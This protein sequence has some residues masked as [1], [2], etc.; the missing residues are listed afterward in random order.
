V[1]RSVSIEEAKALVHDGGEIAFLDLREAGEFGEGHPLFA[2]P[3]PYS[4]LEAQVTALVPLRG[5]RVLLIDGGDG[6][7]GRAAAALEATGYG[8]VM[9]VAGGTPAWAAA[10]HTLFQGVNVPSKTLGELAEHAWHPQTIDAPTLKRWQDEGRDF[11]FFDA[12]PPAE[13][14]KMRVP[15]A[16]CLP[17][18]ELAHR[19]AA[20]I[21]DPAAP[22]VVTCAGRTRGI[23]GVLGLR[24]A[25][26]DRPVYALEN[27]TQ[28]WQLAGFPLER[29]NTAAPYPSL[30]ADAAAATRARADA[31][32]ARHGIATVT[33]AEIASWRADA[34]RTTYLFDLRTPEEIAADPA[35]AFRPAL[36]G[37]LVQATDQWV[38]VRHARLVL[39]DDLGLRG[40]VAAFW[41]RQLG[42]DVA[43]ARIDDALRALPNDPQAVPLPPVA[44][45]AP[46][47]ALQALRD[48]RSQLVDLRASS[49][50]R[51]GHVV[52]AR[53]S[54]RPR[55]EHL[56]LDPHRPVH[57]VGAADL[58]ALAARDLAEQRFTD[59]SAVI[60][61]HAAMAAAGAAIEATPDSPGDE[62]AIDFLRF[63]HDRH[64]GNL[65]S[66]RRYL[67][68]EQGLIAQLDAAERAA[69][70]LSDRAP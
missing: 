22:V 56:R 45:I 65:E 60:G 69:F 46:T 35:P 54:I 16:V 4:T 28:G 23:V 27:G 66:S 61:G 2:I 53:W 62:E 30:G 43:V 38:G 10:G 8:D 7:A 34:T 15:G 12:R 32:M 37:Q 26:I 33:A 40:A 36:S 63:V 49:A 67:A 58:C 1:S 48:G 42:Y 47:E 41:L 70:R 5:V 25:G 13:Y 21:D 55:L 9:T 51:Q 31:V 11:R 17:N 19:F 18:G 64:D 39:L 14:A 68:W 44:A 24:V 3:C 57:L 52:G 59:V 6:V 29:G 50:Y 20:A